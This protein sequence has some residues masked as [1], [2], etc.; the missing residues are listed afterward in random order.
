MLIC[1]AASVAG[2]FASP[3]FTM[4]LPGVHSIA[5][6]SLIAWLSSDCVAASYTAVVSVV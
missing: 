6:Q 4:I 1:V 3:A 2:L 5:Y